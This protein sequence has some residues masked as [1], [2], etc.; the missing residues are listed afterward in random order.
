[1]LCAGT[2]LAQQVGSRA[3]RDASFLSRFDV[4]SLPL[5]MM[6]SALVSVSMVFVVSRWI[7]R[8]GPAHLMPRALTAGA[9]LLLGIWALMFVW[10]RLATI[11]LYVHVSALG[12]VLIS[13][14]WSLF[15]ECFDPRSAKQQIGR[16]GSATTF[17]GL[18]GGVMAERVGAHLPIHWM[19][20]VLAGLCVVAALAVRRMR[21]PEAAPAPAA[22]E[23]VTR[24]MARTF[25]QAP[26]LRNL[27]LL[28]FLST[29]GVAL[30]DYVF[31]SRAAAALDNSA[32]LMRFFAAF[33]TG[34]GLL[35]LGVQTFGSRLAM[36]RLGLART[37][38]T[39]PAG[40]A[41]G[42]LLA[43]AYPGVVSAVLARCFEAVLRGS[44][45]RSSYEALFSPVARRD[46]RAT[47]T[48]VD[49]GF[50]RAG[51][52][53]G[54]GLARACLLLPAFATQAMLAVAVLLAAAAFVI[55]R[56]LQ[57][58][59]VR[60]LEN[61]LL[62][63]VFRLD[64]LDQH[65]ELTRTV[66][67]QIQQR[68]LAS[69]SFP[70]VAPAPAPTQSADAQ[71]A[72]RIRALRSSDLHR[73]SHAL[74]SG[75]ID[76]VCAPHVIA[77]LGRDATYSLAAPV[78]ARDAD[79]LAPHLARAL[80]NAET[81]PTVRRRLPFVMRNSTNPTNV[82]A[83]LGGLHDTRFEVRF[84]C[85]RALAHLHEAH[86]VQLDVARVYA[87]VLRET[88][89]DRRVWESH[90]LLD[91]FGDTEASFVDEYVR[92]RSNR[93]LEHVFT[94]LSLALDSKPLQIAFKGLH[95]DDPHLRGTA[96]EYLEGALPQD[97]RAALWPFL[98]S[99]KQPHAPKRSRDEILDALM[100]S[101]QSI[102][103]NLA[104]LRETG[105]D[106]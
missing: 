14:F 36:Q 7:T 27:A 16:I 69:G 17:G 106:T 24:A 101:H 70:A 68:S 8:H 54:G 44:L 55:A 64:A 50:D 46:R 51:D 87:A 71:L 41:T 5:V 18:A 60:E 43:L 21:P 47:K 91:Q 76:D 61:R 1:M 38:A 97:V 4:T 12:A 59:Y 22:T 13:G 92:T 23:P 66:M 105:G 100:Q 93:S 6:G 79:R 32:A 65:D 3:V 53:L 56:R 80:C 104:R 39:L 57:L 42:S 94:L 96:L 19:L 73:V 58:G 15:N 74:Q 95:T 82:D 25:R 103:I 9:A 83:L 30:L 20:P 29:T 63:G 2:L 48:L 78:L 45:F 49:V 81:D 84:R 77:L 67:V 31:K 102:E 40:L 10:P 52:I 89:V 75:P 28:V 37:V 90:Q 33:Y 35:T 34:A 72:A 11:L 86:G 85:G 62:S 98:E 88:H 99:G 26:Y